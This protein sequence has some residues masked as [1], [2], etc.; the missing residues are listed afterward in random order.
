MLK[1]RDTRIGRV[2]AVKMLLDSRPDLRARFVRASLVDADLLMRSL[3]RPNR[4]QDELR[5]VG[6]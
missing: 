6:N 3:G 4:E 2:V 1:A 5:Q